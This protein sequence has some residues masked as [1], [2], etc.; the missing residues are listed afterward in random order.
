[1]SGSQRNKGARGERE[2]AAAFVVHGW[3]DAN[4]RASG[5]ESQESQGRDLKGTEPWCVQCHFGDHPNPLKKL[6]EARAA[7]RE[8]ELPVAFSKKT[9]GNWVVTMDAS[10]FF[11][12]AQVYE[13]FRAAYPMRAAEIAGKGSA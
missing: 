3:Q 5:E 11:L 2:V 10:T 6:A 4:R 12:L 9:Y 8:G 7:A 1:M 13:R